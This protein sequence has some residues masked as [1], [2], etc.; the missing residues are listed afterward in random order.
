MPNRYGGAENFRE[1][2]NM[3]IL[4]VAVC[5]Y[6]ME[7]YIEECLD[8]CLVNGL[9]DIEVLV[10]NDGSKDR[11]AEIVKGYEEKY[12]DSIILVDKPN[13]G[14]GSNLNLA[15]EKARGKYFRNLD[16]D[17]W[18]GKE[19]FE[20]YIE[21]L[22][23]TDADLITNRHIDC[24]E[25]GPKNDVCRWPEYT[26]KT[27][28]LNDIKGNILFSI[29]D[30][31]FRTELLRKGYEP[32]PEH[33]F[34]TDGLFI[35]RALPKVKTVHFTDIP[36]YCYRLGREGQ[37][38]SPESKKKHYKELLNVNDLILAEYSKAQ[39]NKQHIERLFMSSYRVAVGMLVSLAGDKEVNAKKLIKEK[40]AGLKA[41]F[42]E[43]YAAAGRTK[44]V[45]A[46]RF[47]GYNLLAQLAGLAE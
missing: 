33:H 36:L 26:D 27:A 5:A 15:L 37:S 12:P 21:L 1:V 35:T 18:F 4:T 8:S 3:K 14:W 22:K 31:T 25:E 2:K 6:N 46:M 24:Y 28:E 23:N 45:K 29:W 11:T 19:A 10:M 20:K 7:K 34:Y 39:A 42:P 41:D 32:L 40:E 30:V 43:L 44:L 47:T 16:A 13:G 38:V 17:D 9:E